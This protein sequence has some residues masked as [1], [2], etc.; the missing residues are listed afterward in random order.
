[1]PKRSIDDRWQTEKMESLVAN[2]RHDLE[3]RALRL[4][5]PDLEPK[6]PHAQPEKVRRMKDDLRPKSWRNPGSPLYSRNVFHKLMPIFR[7]L[8]CLFL[9]FPIVSGGMQSS[10]PNP[11]TIPNYR[12]PEVAKAQMEQLA[13]QKSRPY[14]P[15]DL[16]DQF[17]HGI[18]SFLPH[19]VTHRPDPTRYYKDKQ[20]GLTFDKIGDVPEAEWWKLVEACRELAPSSVAYDLTDLKGYTGKEGPMTIDLTTDKRIFCPARI[21]FSILEREIIDTKCE[22]LVEAGVISE[23]RQSEYACNPVL[24]IKR[25]P[26]GTW[27]DKRFCVNFIPINTH[28]KLD[29]YGCH[30]TEELLPRAVRARYLTALDLRSGFHQIPIL[31]E[32]QQRTAFWWVSAKARPP[33]LMAYNRMPFGLKNAPAKF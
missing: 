18:N 25:A 8:L 28:T 23:L 6:S 33:R 22:E 17:Q 11:A 29:P 10:N 12:D 7:A 21:N 14:N 30:R 16:A 31:P 5:F 20:S 2:M 1:M 13:L 24:A 26:D 32:H 27:S 3:I 4:D 9:L 19:G 15:A